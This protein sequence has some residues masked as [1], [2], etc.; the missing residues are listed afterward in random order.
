MNSSLNIVLLIEGALADVLD[1]WGHDEGEEEGGGKAKEKLI[2]VYLS[3]GGG[4]G[5]TA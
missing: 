5:R 1:L 3:G 2:I 4:E